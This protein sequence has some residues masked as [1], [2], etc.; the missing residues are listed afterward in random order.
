[1]EIK[2]RNGHSAVMHNDNQMVVFGGINEV[3]R[4]LDDLCVLNLTEKR[5]TLLQKGTKHISP[6]KLKTLNR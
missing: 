3:T 4:E 1:M 5:W 6:Q 2:G